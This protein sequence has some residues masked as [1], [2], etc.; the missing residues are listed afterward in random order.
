MGITPQNSELKGFFV[1]V[2]KKRC[3]MIVFV[4]YNIILVLHI[5]V[6]ILKFWNSILD[7][8]ILNI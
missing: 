5:F 8:D 2:I 1:I 3:Y 4:D 6:V 7:L